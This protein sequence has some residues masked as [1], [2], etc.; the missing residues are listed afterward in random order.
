MNTLKN[1][2][3]VQTGKRPWEPSD[4]VTVGE[5]LN[6]YDVPLTGLLHHFGGTYLF[7]NLIDA[8]ENSLW[9]YVA[10]TES[11]LKRLLESYGPKE[12]DAA[13]EAMLKNRCVTMATASNFEIRQILT[14]DA[15]LEGSLELAQ[16]FIRSLST[17]LKR[18]TEE[19]KALAGDSGLVDA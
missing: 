6:E 15:G 5:V 12:Q 3:P 1:V 10:L 7:T 11:D 14:L 18:D 2:L 8:G 13:V 9:A 16:R 4:L 19:T 17:Q